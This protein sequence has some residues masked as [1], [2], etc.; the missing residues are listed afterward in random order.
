[1]ACRYC[2]Y[3]MRNSNFFPFVLHC[4]P[5]AVAVFPPNNDACVGVLILAYGIFAL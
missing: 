5:V 4:L 1:M 3:V 2:F